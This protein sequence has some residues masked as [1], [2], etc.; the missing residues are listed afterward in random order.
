MR[1]GDIAKDFTNKSESIQI[2]QDDHSKLDLIIKETGSMINDMNMKIHDL[3][4]TIEKLKIMMTTFK[5]NPK[6]M[7]TEN[8]VDTIE[9]VTVDK[10]KV[11]CTIIR[12][13]F[14]KL[15]LK[16]ESVADKTVDYDIQN[17]VDMATNVI[18]ENVANIFITIKHVNDVNTLPLNFIIA[19]F[20]MKASVRTVQLSKHIQTTF[21]KK[22]FLDYQ[23]V[24]IFIND[25]GLVHLRTAFVHVVWSFLFSGSAHGADILSGCAGDYCA[26]FSVIVMPYLTNL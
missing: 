10:K 3:I 12:M 9:E 19:N 18:E 23:V 4:T 17:S 6:K 20:A 11:A 21:M 1:I 24:Q 7:M 22:K 2:L 13:K 16:L 8:I 5:I 25:H 15:I 14:A 26:G